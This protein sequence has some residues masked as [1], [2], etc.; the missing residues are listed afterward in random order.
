MILRAHGIILVVAW[1]VCPAAG[2]FIARY[3]KFALGVWWFRLHVFFLFVGTGLLTI[4]GIVLIYLYKAPPHLENPHEI[5]GFTVGIAM[6]LQIILGVVSDR[7]FDPKR[8]STPIQDILH[9]WMG[10]IVVVLAI[11]NL[12]LG[13][14]LYGQD[15]PLD[16][17]YLIALGVVVGVIAL[18]FVAG[19]FLIG[20]QPC[21][22]RGRCPLA[23]LASAHT[24]S[25]GRLQFTVGKVDA[26]VAIL[27]S[28]DH[29]LIEF[30]AN[31]LPD[32]VSTGSIVNVTVERN[33]EEEQRQRDEFATMQREIFEIYSQPPQPP[34]IEI[35]AVTQTSVII[36]WQ[37]LVLHSAT[38]RGLDV[39]RNGQKLNLHINP[40][41]TSVKLSGLDVSHEYEI[42]V[43]LRTSAGNFT[44]NK[45]RVKTHSMD[46]LTGLNP[47]F[48]TFSNDAEIETLIELLAR[49]G[50]SYTD[51]LSTDNTHL[52]CTLPKGPKYEKA[53]ELNIPVVSPEF[54][55]ACEQQQKVM[56]AHTFYLSKQ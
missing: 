9:W 17:G 29:H 4:A 22:H 48:G 7:L 28:P 41:A 38:F 15:Y 12:F 51:D 10:R 46:N 18:A 35:K 8:T 55:K 32:G 37:P 56:P 6:L 40:L 21:T 23:L 34:A 53:L 27:L 30:P 42:W 47:S 24:P 44:S 13:L 25:R 16:K 50:A 43:V 52:V 1:L 11:V 36:K 2:I 45:L 26:G 31:L 14:N 3:L 33:P 49:I 39:F 54:L 5:L 20:Q 19:Q